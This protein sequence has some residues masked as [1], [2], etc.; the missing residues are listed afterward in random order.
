MPPKL[1]KNFATN[2]QMAISCSKIIRIRHM[3]LLFTSIVAVYVKKH[4]ICLICINLEEAMV[5]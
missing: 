3:R 4:N 2:I 5:I 1:E